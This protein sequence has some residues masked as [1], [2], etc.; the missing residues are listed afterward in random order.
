MGRKAKDLSVLEAALRG[1]ASGL[2]GGA[3]L[4]LA[5]R[6]EHAGIL[7][8]FEGRGP[9][10]GK[11]IRAAGRKTGL[12]L[13]SREVTLAEIGGY[14]AYSAFLGALFG[15]A[16][17]RL[18]LTTAARALLES[19]FV[20]AASVP[21]RGA[22]PQGGRKRSPASRSLRKPRLPVDAGDVGLAATRMFDR[23][24]MG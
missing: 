14:L 20:Y 8:N 18:P 10:W 4:L 17:R 11:R 22:V 13:S 21:I 15:V 7:T 12:R 23:F 6:L 1:A 5:A 3:A 19:G 9:R 24:A 16:R 2:V